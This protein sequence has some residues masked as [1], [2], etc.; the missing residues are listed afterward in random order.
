VSLDFISGVFS[1]MRCL[2]EGSFVFRGSQEMT[3]SQLELW[4]QTPCGHRP[5]EQL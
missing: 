2:E 5:V 3:L 1:Q 4:Q